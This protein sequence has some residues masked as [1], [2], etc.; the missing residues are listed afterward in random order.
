MREILERLGLMTNLVF[1]VDVPNNDW[2]SYDGQSW[3]DHPKHDHDDK[4][5]KMIRKTNARRPK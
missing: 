4:W 5:A 3:W 2:W 1:F